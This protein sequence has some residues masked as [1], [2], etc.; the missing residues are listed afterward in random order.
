VNDHVAYFLINN[1]ING[2]SNEGV[3]SETAGRYPGFE[4]PR[5]SRKGLLFTDGIMWGG[6]YRSTL[7]V[8][9]TC[10]N[11]T[12]FQAGS[13]FHGGYE[14]EDAVDFASPKEY[15]WCEEIEPFQCRENVPR[16]APE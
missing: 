15:V 7:K 4:F 9:G 5:G 1:V 13:L 11:S 12:S 6:F 8:G 10:F 14:D 3:G 2:Y 16:P